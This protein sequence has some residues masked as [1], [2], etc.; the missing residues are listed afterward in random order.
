MINILI[1][2]KGQFIKM[3]PILLELEKRNIKYNFINAKQHGISLDKMIKSFKTNE[4]DNVMW[5]F[6]KDITNTKEIF[7]WLVIN[8]LK[9]SFFFERKKF[10]KGRK[11]ILLIHGDAPPVLLGLITGFFN[12]MDICHIEAG[13]RSHNLFAPFPEEIIRI[14]A[15]K[16]SKILFTMSHFASRNVIGKYE[17]KLIF[18]LKKNTT[19]DAVRIALEF[20]NDTLKKHFVLVS[21]HRFETIQSKEKLEFIIDLIMRI[22]EEEEIIFPLHESTKSSLIRY[23]L[24]EKIKLNKKILITDLMDY[25]TFI[26]HIKEAKYLITD[27]GGPQEESHYLGTPSLILREETERIWD[28]NCISGFDK[29][30]I[31]S[32]LT[33]PKNYRSKFLINNYSPSKIIVDIIERLNYDK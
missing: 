9:Y 7:R 31:D 22:S 2:T 24:Y 10:K 23:N 8:T 27:G 33:N 16:F 21:I 30:K 6:G 29:N 25:F 4:P 3:A 5:N 13:C 15:D 1:G 12:L 17:N 19:Y 32:F 26:N 18:N 14:L 20:P 11:D 28:N